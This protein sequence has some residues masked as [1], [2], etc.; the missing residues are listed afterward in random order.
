MTSFHL[1]AYKNPLQLVWHVPLAQVLP[2]PQLIFPS[3]TWYIGIYLNFQ[4]QKSFK[5]QHLPHSHL[6]TSL[7]TEGFSE[8]VESIVV[9]TPTSAK[10]L[11]RQFKHRSSLIIM[12]SFCSMYQ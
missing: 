1:L 2:C 7:A 10:V 3:K 6:E 9:P 4:Q 11:P 12:L 8:G 5:I